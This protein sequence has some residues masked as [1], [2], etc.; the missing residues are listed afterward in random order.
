MHLWD[1]GGLSDPML[2]GTMLAPSPTSASI[3]VAG[4][5]IFEFEGGLKFLRQDKKIQ[6]AVIVMV[7]GRGNCV[8][9]ILNCAALPSGCNNDILTQCVSGRF[10][11]L[12]PTTQ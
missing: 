6:N 11:A 4:K 10:H 3:K 12:E 2:Q 8:Q 7:A 9:P 1:P 5:C